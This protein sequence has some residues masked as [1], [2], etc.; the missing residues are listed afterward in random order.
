MN[1]ITDS[2]G[3]P[4]DLE[5]LWPAS[6]GKTN[7]FRYQGKICHIQSEKGDYTRYENGEFDNGADPEKQILFDILSSYTY[8]PDI[9]NEVISL[10]FSPE[11]GQ[12]YAALY[13]DK[14]DTFLYPC[15][16]RY[17]THINATRGEV[18]VAVRTYKA[19]KKRMVGYY[20]VDTL[21]RATSVKTEKPSLA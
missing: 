6:S 20:G 21:S 1:T 17:S 5:K 14:N 12:V 10:E 16:S 3:A 11:D 13:S 9:L 19:L 4:L 8:D 2:E 7:A 18:N 15:D